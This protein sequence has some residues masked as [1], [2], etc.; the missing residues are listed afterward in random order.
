MP[1]K[2]C[3]TSFAPRRCG[4][5]AIASVSSL[6][7]PTVW[8]MIIDTLS[9]GLDEPAGDDGELIHALNELAEGRVVATV[10]PVATAASPAPAAPEPARSAAPATAAIVPPEAVAKLVVPDQVDAHGE[11]QSRGQ[12]TIRVGVEVLENLMGLVS[13]LVLTRNQLLQILRTTG[14]PD[15]SAGDAAEGS[16]ATP[17]QRL[18]QLTHR[19]AGRRHEDAHAADRQTPGTRCRGWSATLRTISARRSSWSPSAPTPN[20]I[21][22]CWN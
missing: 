1:A 11:Q 5:T 16:L 9:R 12:T 7:P 4:S 14:R 6:P 17:M 21:A 10:V 18:S 13:E 20:S 15:Q 19:P 3:S 8:R 2:P 22:R